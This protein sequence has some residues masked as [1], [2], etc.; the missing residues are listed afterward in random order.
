MVKKIAAA[1]LTFDVSFRPLRVQTEVVQQKDKRVKFV[2][3]ITVAAPGLVDAA[4]TLGGR[5][6][7]KQALAEY[8]RNPGKFGHSHAAASKVVIKVFLGN[9]EV[10]WTTI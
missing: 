4:V 8:L 5:Y 2:T 3:K 1:A 10:A 7:V 6:S 9:M